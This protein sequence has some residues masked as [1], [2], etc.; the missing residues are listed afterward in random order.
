MY[1]ITH[2][3]PP[4][5]V[6]FNLYMVQYLYLASNFNVGICSGIFLNVQ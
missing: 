4:I 2:T 5:I 1:N 6:S 3:L